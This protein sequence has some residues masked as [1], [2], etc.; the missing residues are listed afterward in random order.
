MTNNIKIKSDSHDAIEKK[1]VEDAI[2]RSW[3]VDDSDINV[4]VTGTTVTLSGTVD[5][6]YQK[7]EAGHIAWKT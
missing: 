1:E 7:E 3:S 2:G 6:W 5:S 4:S